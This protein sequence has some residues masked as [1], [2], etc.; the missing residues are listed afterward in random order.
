[1]TVHRLIP[2]IVPEDFS[3]ARDDKALIYWLKDSPRQNFGDFLS[4]FLYDALAYRS[5]PHDALCTPR[6]GFQKLHMI[7]S[8]I[9]EWHINADL[10]ELDT[11]QSR[12]I[13]FWGCGM[14]DEKTI[15][16]EL[17]RRCVF[18]GVRGA[19]SR[20]C[21]G[22]PSDTPTCDPGLLLPLLYRPR[23]SESYSGLSIC[24]PHF[25]EK[26]SCHA[27]MELTEAD[28]IVGSAIPATRKAVLE[29]IDIIASAAFLLTGALHGAVVA[30][31]YGVP[32]AFLDNG[33]INLPFKWRDFAASVDV[34]VIFAK[35]IN[36]G[37][38]VYYSEMMHRIRMP[39]LHSLLDRAPI[40]P[41]PD[42]ISRARA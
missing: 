11:G 36:E 7:G 32:F 8:V 42:L 24:M 16:P 2:L 26:L 1:M 18:M 23:K 35:T 28:R 6:H 10:A 38:D 14:R 27:L 31:A 20:D 22:L 9:S 39:N 34:P 12:S 4:E 3:A 5:S 29:L 30:C 41:P 33:F 15:G 40:A 37:R 25:N 21:L 13:G 19:L 17:M